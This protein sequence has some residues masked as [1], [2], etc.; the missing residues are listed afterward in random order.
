MQP[1]EIELTFANSV[2]QFDTGN[3]HRSTL[4]D[5]EP[6]HRVD[7]DFTPQWSCSIMLLRYFDDRRRVSFQRELCAGNSRTAR[8]DAA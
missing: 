7:T 5:L 6:E 2:Q 4:E 8:W 3:R 1:T